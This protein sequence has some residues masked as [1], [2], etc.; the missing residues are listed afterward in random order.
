MAPAKVEESYD[1]SKD[2]VRRTEN[3]SPAYTK[4]QYFKNTVKL[5]VPFRD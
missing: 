4:E 3:A 1:D 2:A 5:A